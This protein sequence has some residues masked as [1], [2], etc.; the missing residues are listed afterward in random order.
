MIEKHIMIDE[1]KKI[2][3]PHL[4]KDIVT[5]GFVKDIE[6]DGD[7]VTVFLEITPSSSPLKS[8][9][10][11][12]IKHALKSVSSVSNVSIITTIQ[13]KQSA[14]MP[15][16]SGLE[17]VSNIIAV[18]SCKGG[19]GK[20]TVTVN[21]AYSLALKGA[22]VGVFDADVYGPS[23]PTM[24]GTTT[25]VLVPSGDL[26]SPIIS[27]NVKLMSF[28]YAQNSA[29]NDSPA[30]LRGPMVSQII[31]QLLSH[32]DWGELDYLF[33]DMPPGTGDI[34]LTIGQMIPLTAAVI[35]TTPQHI[36]FIDVVKGIDMFDTLNVPTIGMV[37]NM[38]FFRC[39]DCD[40]LHYPFGQGAMKKLVNQFGFEHAI[41]LPITP[42]VSTQ[43]DQGTPYVISDG[44]SDVSRLFFSLA[45]TVVEEV[46]KLDH[47]ESRIPNVGYESKKGILI[48]FPK[49]DLHSIDPKLLRESCTCAHCVDELTGKSLIASKQIPAGVYPFSMNPVGNYALGINW[50][51][52]HSSLYPYSFLE[53]FVGLK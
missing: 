9:F 51:D 47:L 5:L 30:I 42:A 21:L 3:D 32:T 25:S 17:K 50:S 10:E 37:E 15:S 52:N 20:S 11:S 1:L 33:I 2:I 45:D 38:S 4:K 53:Q 8:Q 49:T 19:V 34:Q 35:V 36:S 22:K 39:D 46:R 24:T 13:N 6:I 14:I 26:I 27:E 7:N 29:D 28:G 18:S 43:C 48:H 23:L 41:Q 44:S 40:K 12:L 16:G 31:N